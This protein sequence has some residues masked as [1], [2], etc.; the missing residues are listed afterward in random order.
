MSHYLFQG[1]YS[2]EAWSALVRRPRNRL[3][4]VKSS[5]EKLGGRVEGGW[6][7]FGDHDVILVVRMPN[8][9]NA[10]AF[11]IAVAAGGALK[12][13]RTTPLLTFEEGVKAMRQAGKVGYR[14]PK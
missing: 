8:N 14:P 2:S 10:A 4:A 13:S 7:S 9:V 6:L 12:S 11:S 1:S 3:Q 5:I